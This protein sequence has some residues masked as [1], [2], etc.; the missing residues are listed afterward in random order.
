MKLTKLLYENVLNEFNKNEI[1]AI[2]TKLN[3]QR[4]PELEQILN[5]LKSQ[6]VNYK[7]LKLKLGSEIKSIEDLNSL[8]TTS[9]TDIRKSDKKD[10]KVIL[11]NDKFFIVRPESTEASCYYGKGTKW[12]TAGISNNQFNNYRIKNKVTIYYIF[13]KLKK[14]D[15]RWSKV[16]IAIYPE[17]TKFI[18]QNQQSI[19]AFDAKDKSID[20]EE[21]LKVKG[22]NLNLF[23]NV[24]S[25]KELWNL[26]YIVK[27][28]YTKNSDGTIDVIGNVN[29]NEMYLGKIPYKFGKVTGNF[30]CSYNKLTSL[31]GAPESVGRKFI[32]SNNE[33]TSLE[34]APKLVK[35]EFDCSYNKNLT[36]LEGAPKEVG[37]LQCSS[38]K[39]TSLQ[40]S[41]AKVNVNY[42]CSNNEL[43]SLK[44]APLKIKGQFD[45]SNTNV[46]SLE[47]APKEVGG[48][49]ICYKNSKKFTEE[50]VRQISNIKGK[51]FL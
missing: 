40:W 44:G 45:C 41:P 3:I 21:Y 8:V 17:G 50:D 31:E 43:K 30:V 23:T 47:G 37:S 48:N 20:A 24:K 29:F 35:G 25:T 46:T 14:E 6:G 1:E 11:D 5:K 16:A 49:F 34:G 12:C 19:E 7:E 51:V 28:T 38:T 22:L 26:D 2:S 10:A 27:G 33:L 13:D 39:L 4:T 18:N 9:K 42:D 32:C 15:P 36:S